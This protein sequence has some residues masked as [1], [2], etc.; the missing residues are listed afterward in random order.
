MKRLERNAAMDNI[1]AEI[2]KALERK[3]KLALATLITREGSAPRAVGAKYLIRGDG[4]SVGSIGGGCVEAEVWQKAQNVMEK[5]QAGVL[6]FKLTAEQLAEGG[7]ICGGNIDIFL[8]PLKHDF[9]SIYQEV[10]KINQKGGSALLVTLIS[11]D[12]NSPGGEGSKALIK[13]SGEKVGFLSDGEELEEAILKENQG[14]LRAKKPMVMVLSSE[15][16]DSLWEKVEVL[17]E[18]I[19]SEPTVYIFG[20]GHISQQ[21]APLAKMVHFKAVVIDD[22]EMFASRERFPEAD[23]VIVSEFEKCFDQLCIDDTSY[24]IIVTRGHLYD[25]FVL[26][27]AVKTNARYIGMIGSKKKIRTLYQNLMKKGVT[28][29]TL[30]QVYA[31]IGIDINSETPEEIAVSI[32]AELIKIR[33]EL[34]S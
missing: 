8:E 19:F 16:E 18:P 3:E 25:G 30:D 33:G 4:T 11:V 22:R 20:G 27:Q 32:V 31:P 28:K 23:E 34:I 1:Y 12:G 21:L 6:H 24:I 14:L 26:E 17:L 9:L 13:S 5:E 10:M 29:E 15:K 2:V 7:L